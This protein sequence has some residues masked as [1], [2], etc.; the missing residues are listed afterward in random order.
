V[1][2]AGKAPENIGGLAINSPDISKISI[3]ANQTGFNA[4]DMS[5]HE[6]GFQSSPLGYVE[7]PDKNGSHL[8]GEHLQDGIDDMIDN[9]AEMDMLDGDEEDQDDDPEILE[10]IDRR[11][12]EIIE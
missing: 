7:S 9:P 5:G 10:E 11:H 6:L 3:P 1:L 2:S 12:E 8:F 4:N